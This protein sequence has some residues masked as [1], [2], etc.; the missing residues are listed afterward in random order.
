MSVTIDINRS[1]RAVAAEPGRDLLS[2]LADEAEMAALG[3]TFEAAA[4]KLGRVT[5][6]RTFTVLTEEA[7]GAVV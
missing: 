2:A 5:V 1:K 3:V 4:A 6:D 7:R